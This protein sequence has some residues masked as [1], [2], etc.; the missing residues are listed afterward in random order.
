MKNL[1]QQAC[2]GDQHAFEKIVQLHKRKLTVV[3]YSYT[4]DYMAAQDMVQETFIKA[5]QCIHQLK[6]PTY[7]STWLCKILIRQCIH[8]LN[9]KKQ[10]MKLEFELQQLQ[11]IQA[12]HSPQ[13]DE[14]YEAI[15]KLKEQYRNVIVLH[16]FYD[17]KVQEIA[18]LFD[19]PL[20]TI[21]IHLHRARI[22]LKQLLESTQQTSKKDVNIMLH[23]LKEAALH[24]FSI[25][26]D[27]TLTIEDI[28]EKEAT[29]FWKGEHSADEG[30]YITLTT[31]GKLLSLSQP[32][33]STGEAI[34]TEEQR[35]I[36]EK[37]ITSQYIEA[38]HY[39]S[40]A[41]I[42]TKTDSTRFYYKQLIGG[43]PLQS[44]S[45]VVEV[46]TSGQLMNFEYKPYQLIPPKIPARFATKEPIL[47]QLKQSAWTARLEYLSSDYYTVPRS[48]LYVVYHSTYLYHSFDATS[49]KDLSIALED[50]DMES[51][52]Q[53]SFIPLPQVE[54][55]EPLSTIEE[56]IGLP[57]SMER[58]RQSAL[59][60]GYIGM[61]WRDCTYEPPS[62]KSM[63]QFVL[64]RFEHTVK[65]TVNEA[66]GELRGFVWFKERTG[67]LSLS[68]NQCEE[69]AVKFLN[70]YFPAFVPYLQ[71]KVTD[72]SFNEAH[73]ALF[74][75]QLVIEN[76]PIEGEFFMLSVNQTTGLV[77]MLMTP[78]LE[79]NVL[80]EFEKQPLLPVEQ[81]KE[82]LKRVDVL[83]EWDKRYEMD[84]PVEMLIYRF[85]KRKSKLPIKY[86]DATTGELILMKE[87]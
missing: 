61:V 26:T 10:A 59:D 5:Y 65:A 78:K 75:F 11:L 17:F 6:E 14:L 83:L 25:P 51:E 48:G 32:V 67:S 13:F 38:L 39:F 79:L 33:A 23:H 8:H 46:S 31:D 2:T 84:N 80:E 7:F 19:K 37:F 47:E 81:A 3:A 9:T 35:Q 52:G 40:L 87:G 55:N 57:P 85:K 56:I 62:D 42:Q 77:D 28:D 64:D 58:I 72:A 36:A 74:H 27:Y 43:I 82:S 76:L 69:I 44:A 15:N 66:T 73:R 86:I 45:C 70:T 16:Y 63:N 53:E 34:S 60:D 49:G 50:E 21:K 24:Y 22:Q 12:D 20:N 30:Y 29:F 1:I 4:K 41:T 54:P 68:F 71:M 18:N